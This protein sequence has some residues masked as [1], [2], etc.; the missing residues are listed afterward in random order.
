MP[1]CN[2][3]DQQHLKPIS[4]E[5]I[6]LLHQHLQESQSDFPA[7]FLKCQEKY[8]LVDEEQQTKM[9]IRLGEIIREHPQIPAREL[10]ALIKTAQ[11]A[12]LLQRYLMSIQ[13]STSQNSEDWSA[14]FKA[15]DAST[16]WEE[17]EHKVTELNLRLQL[18][19]VPDENQLVELQEDFK[20]HVI[21]K[22]NQFLLSASS[23]L[24]RETFTAEREQ[25]LADLLQAAWITDQDTRE[26][27]LSEFALRAK[28]L[29]KS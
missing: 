2:F 26:F 24:P 27:Y 28:E 5:M 8:L 13:A 25:A 21:Q 12:P 11:L 16:S 29:L 22:L 3:A 19:E 10:L 17:L 15:L 20:A 14:R 4:E 6:A 9:A 23:A 7:R 18:A 1:L